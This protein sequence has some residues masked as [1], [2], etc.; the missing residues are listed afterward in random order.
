MSGKV[1]AGSG[2]M[3]NFRHELCVTVLQFGPIGNASRASATVKTSII[4]QASQPAE[5]DGEFVTR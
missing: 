5:R 2:L 1:A 4:V 3:C